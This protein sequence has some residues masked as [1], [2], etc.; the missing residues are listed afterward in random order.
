MVLSNNITHFLL[1]SITF[2]VF[3]F[4]TIHILN[5]ESFV[6]ALYHVKES[7]IHGRG[8]FAS[9]KL[10]KDSDLGVIVVR[11]E[12][13]I[14]FFRRYNTDRF[15]KDK[16]QKTFKEHRGLGRYLNHSETPNCKIIVNNNTCSLKTI[17]DIQEGDELTANYKPFRDAYLG[18]YMIDVKT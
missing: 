3:I 7:T 16:N 13:N 17:K 12:N 14:R 8:L 10:N 4:A 1:F 9:V 6:E 11:G 2:L 5:N 18:G 15:F